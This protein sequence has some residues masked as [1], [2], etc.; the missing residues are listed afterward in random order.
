MNHIGRFDPSEREIRNINPGGTGSAIRAFQINSNVDLTSDMHELAIPRLRPDISLMGCATDPALTGKDLSQYQ[1]RLVRSRVAFVEVKATAAQGPVSSTGEPIGELV[2]QAADYA[3]IHMSASPFQLY[4]VGT[5]VYAR[6]VRVAIFHRRGIILS[7]ESIL[8]RQDTAGWYSFIRIVRCMTAEMSPQQFGLDP[9]AVPLLPSPEVS[10]RIQ[11]TAQRLEVKLPDHFPTFTISLHP[12]SARRWVTI[13][14]LYSSLSLIG[15]GTTVWVVQELEGGLPSGKVAIMKTA[16]RNRARTSESEMYQRLVQSESH[17][18]VAEFLDGGDVQLPPPASS[19][20]CTS[21][22]S[23]PAA[24]LEGDLV[25]HR[26]LLASVGR[27][28]WMAESEEQLILALK[29][30]I[31]GLYY[32]R[33]RLQ[34]TLTHV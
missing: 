12:Q 30:A 23:S 14:P 2:Q 31:R 19:V 27:P 1:Q 15:R 25:L 6:R 10:S 28:L 5:L 11:Q 29:G 8:D 32:L 18:C 26:L 4:S 24:G 22:F 17:P 33:I 13:A 21:A 7:P 34:D 3:R 20:I 16:W 9:T